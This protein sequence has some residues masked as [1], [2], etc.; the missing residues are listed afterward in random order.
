MSGLRIDAEYPTLLRCGEQGFGQ[1]QGQFI[2]GDLVAEVGPLRGRL[3]I[4]T[5]NHPLE[6]GT[7]LTH[8]NVDRAAVLVVEQRDGVDLA[9]VDALEVDPHQ[10]LESAGTRYRMRDAVLA[11]EVEVVQPVG[12]VLVARRDL[13]EFVLHGGGEVVVH[14]AAEML[15]EKAGD[16]E[17][18]PRRDQRAALLM[19]VSAILDGFDDRGIR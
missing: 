2:G 10:F 8:P 3:A 16:R 1:F 5:E 18:H 19:H 11:A 13:V 9:G 12:A 7:V 6:I 15:L 17:G 14:Q 4:L